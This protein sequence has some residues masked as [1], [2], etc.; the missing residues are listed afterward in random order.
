MIQVELNG[1]LTE[2]SKHQ[3]FALAKR[4]EIGPET[5]IVACGDRPKIPLALGR[6]TG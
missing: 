4:G 1:K 2:V 5:R 3:L 6:K